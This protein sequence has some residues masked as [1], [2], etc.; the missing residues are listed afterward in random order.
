MAESQN[1]HKVLTG[2][3]QIGPRLTPVTKVLLDE[4]MVE[5]NATVSEIVEEALQR[6]LRP[7]DMMDQQTIY[8]KL[9]EVEHAVKAILEV[10]TQ[11][12]TPVMPRIATNEE[13]YPDM[14]TAP[15]PEPPP[16]PQ[17]R[18]RGWRRWFL[19]EVRR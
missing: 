15:A 4:A 11:Q 6:Y 2:R 12:A 13:L 14:P 19:V 8:A 18:L 10:L 1:A 9:V 16:P 5:R 17:S 3:T 7:D